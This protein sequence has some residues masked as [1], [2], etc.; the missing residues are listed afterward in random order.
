MCSN[1]KAEYAHFYVSPQIVNPQ[2]LGHIPLSQIR[3]FTLCFYDVHSFLQIHLQYGIKNI[4]KKLCIPKRFARVSQSSFRNKCNKRIFK[5]KLLEKFFLLILAIFNFQRSEIVFT[6]NK[7]A[8]VN[9]TK[10]TI[11]KKSS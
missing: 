11:R 5:E 9:I 1:C 8:R 10:F 3:K 2:I 6:N 7:K 4:F